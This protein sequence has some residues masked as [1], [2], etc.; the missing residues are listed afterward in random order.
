MITKEVPMALITW[1]DSYSVKVKDFD[2][3]HQ[4]L[5]TLINDLHEA[6]KAGKAKNIMEMMLDEL[7]SYTV[8]HFKS[9]EDQMKKHH[10][11]EMD[12]HLE[13]HKGFVQKVQDFQAQF[14]AGKAT[15]S[16]DI[17][18][19]LRDWLINH[20]NGTDKKYSDFFNQKGVK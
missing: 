13:E 2:Q 18:N 6:M 7:G 4:K 1:S 3:Q 10:Y 8:Y 14:K 9:E 11:P 5:V 17:S 15:L 20:I 16:L 12:K 19:F